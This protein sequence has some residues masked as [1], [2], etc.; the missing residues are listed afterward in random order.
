EWNQQIGDL[1]ASN[2]ASRML[3]LQSII[4]TRDGA[5]QVLHF[6][7]DSVLAVFHTAS[8]AL[9]RSLEIQRVLGW[10]EDGARSE[11][12]RPKLRIGLH[13]GEVLVQE[14][15]RLEI[16]S[17]HI[18]RAHRIMEAAVPGQILAS[19]A[20]VEAGKDFINVA[21]EFLAIQYHGEFY[22][23]GAGA[24]QLCEVVDVRFRKP[25][26]PQLCAGNKFETALLG[27]LE[28]AGYRSLGR[29]G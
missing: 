5:G 1:E 24:T 29:L 9:N 3:T 22:L 25:Q 8:A 27:R 11:R 6:G 28:L 19:E 4:I 23:K 18:N 20:V 15:E 13:M 10:V 2:I 16:M 7:G 17:R 14:G 21:K 26:P 12:A